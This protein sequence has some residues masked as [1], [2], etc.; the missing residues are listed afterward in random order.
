M[1]FGRF[2]SKERIFFGA[3]EG[4]QVTELDG[5]PFDRY[6]ATPRKHSLAALKTLVPCMPHN[7]YCAGLNYAA[8]VE[9]A[10]S[11]TGANLKLPAKADVGYR[12]PNAL[13]A[14]G[15]ANGFA[16]YRP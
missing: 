16:S 6:K 3:V 7:F 11:R 12:S 9:W 15:E 8:H 10:N 1:R 5:S 14:T 2:E 13:I 4:D